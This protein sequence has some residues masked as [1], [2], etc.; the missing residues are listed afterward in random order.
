MQATAGT[1]KGICSLFFADFVSDAV[2][3]Q[4]FERIS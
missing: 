4:R 1:V 2:F 3:R